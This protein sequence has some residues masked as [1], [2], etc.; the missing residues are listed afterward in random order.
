MP[1]TANSFLQA[2]NTTPQE[3]LIT[4][5]QQYCTSCKTVRMRFVILLNGR[6]ST[7]KDIDKAQKKL[8]AKKNNVQLIPPTKAA[9]K[10]HVKRV[11]GVK[12]GYQHQSFPFHPAG[13]GSRKTR[14]CTRHEA[15]HICNELLSCNKSCP[16]HSK[17]K[18]VALENECT[19]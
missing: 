19:A 11:G 16:K 9:L 5:L 12:H 2:S 1:R 17:C 13:A 10:E 4:S 8:F 3:E 6:T 18:K 15:T 14:R 7:C